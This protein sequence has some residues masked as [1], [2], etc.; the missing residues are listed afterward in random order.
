MELIYKIRSRGIHFSCLHHIPS[1]NISF[2]T[3]LM[4]MLHETTCVIYLFA[5][6][7]LS[8]VTDCCKR[9]VAKLPHVRTLCPKK[10]VPL[11]FLQHLWFLL[12]NFNHFFTVTIRSNHYT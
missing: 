2:I 6:S 4:N 12:T 11:L 8:V 5:F 10:T 3:L 1:C 7:S 9:V